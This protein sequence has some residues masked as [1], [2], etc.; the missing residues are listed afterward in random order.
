MKFIKDV[1]RKS[2]EETSKKYFDTMGKRF[3]NT[4]SNL[5]YSMFE[6]IM[7][8]IGIEN[9]Y[10]LLKEYIDGVLLKNRNS[11]AHGERIT[12][13]REEFMDVVDRVN[14]IM[15]NYKDEILDSAEN[16]SFLK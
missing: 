2:E 9:R 13:N 3:I 8:I 5:N 11:I 16:K 4:N 14:N 15:I 1:L 6:E 7:S 12:L 10:T